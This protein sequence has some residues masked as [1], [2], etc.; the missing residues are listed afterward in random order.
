MKG[1]QLTQV[2]FGV[3]AI[4]LIGLAGYAWWTYAPTV[5]VRQRVKERLYDADS[6][7]FSNVTFNADKGAGCGQVNAKNRMG[8]YTGFTHFILFADGSM[9]FQPEPPADDANID[10]KIEVGG[11]RI[12][13]AHLVAGYC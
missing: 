10:K 5:Q 7:K 13:Y 1:A 11:K 6:A 4:L 12:V 2:A 3:T 8:G 9:Q